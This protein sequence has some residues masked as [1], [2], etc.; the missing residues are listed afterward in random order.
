MEKYVIEPGVVGSLA[1]DFEAV[2]TAHAANIGKRLRLVTEKPGILLDSEDAYA[3]SWHTMEDAVVITCTDSVGV[4]WPDFQMSKPQ[5]SL[6]IRWDRTLG[7]FDGYITLTKDVEYAEPGTYSPGYPEQ[8]TPGG[9]NTVSRVLQ[10]LTLTTSKTYNNDNLPLYQIRIGGDG[11]VGIVADLRSEYAFAMIQDIA[12]V[13][14]LPPRNVGM[15]SR[16]LISEGVI[17]D[18]AAIL[19]VASPL[20]NA[21][22]SKVM[23]DI[24]WYAAVS[25]SDI[26]AY[27]V[28]CAPYNASGV[29]ADSIVFR[30][31]VL[32]RGGDYKIAIPA[33]HGVKYSASVRSIS[34]RS[35]RLPGEWISTSD[36]LAGADLVLAPPDAPAI[37]IQRMM[38]DPLTINLRIEVG[39]ATPKPYKVQLFKRNS[40]IYGIGFQEQVLVYEGSDGD[41]QLLAEASEFPQ[42][43]GRVVASGM[44]CSDYSAWQSVPDGVPPSASNDISRF[45]LSMPVAIKLNASDPAFDESG[46]ILCGS[47]YAPNPGAQIIGLDFVSTGSYEYRVFAGGAGSPA[48]TPAG[49][50]CF[51]VAPHVSP[52]EDT[53]SRLH[54]SVDGETNLDIYGW[55][56]NDH[57]SMIGVDPSSSYTPYHRHWY[58]NEDDSTY[59]DNK[60]VLDAFDGTIRLDVNLAYDIDETQFSGNPDPGCIIIIVGTLNIT[61][62]PTL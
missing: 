26:W 34:S 9:V 61:M 13:P 17:S 15:R 41:V 23:L 38:N 32:P 54:C 35:N 5:G 3:V 8:P 11:S 55:F 24:S 30:E 28:R 46:T 52:T 10:S 22:A 16:T 59:T 25:E 40:T 47:F 33:V 20:S 37:E 43:R 7:S 60:L 42:F 58:C 51:E 2:Q 19:N 27:D 12:V 57:G 21:A 45:T 56:N 62:E 1:D 4:V 29:I 14:P 36:V 31:I 18:E 53:T 49:A 39:P 44:I 50:I 6:V 48:Q